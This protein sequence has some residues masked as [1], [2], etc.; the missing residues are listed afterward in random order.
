MRNIFEP[1][2][3]PAWLKQ[4]LS[5]IR[6][7]LGDIWPGPLRLKDYATV[8]RPAAADFS[9]GLIYDST[10]GRPAWSNGSAWFEAM[11]YT[12][13]AALSRTN[14]TNV[15]LTLGGSP[16]TA[17][18]AATSLTLGWIGT[19]SVA[20]G[21]SGAATL[22]GL[23]VGNGTSAFTTIAPGTGV[24]TALALN[25]GSAG[26]F[27]TFNGALGTP[28]SGTLTNATGL[29][30]STGVSG[31]ASGIATFL[32]TPSSTNLAA[33]VTNETG[34]GALVFATSPTLVTPIL[35]TPTS[36]TLTNC[37]GLPISSGVSGLGTGIAT[38]LATP[39]SANLASAL[40]DETGSGSVVFSV[41][42]TFTGTIAAAAASFSGNVNLGDAAAD[43]HVLKGSTKIAGGE[44]AGSLT[45]DRIGSL[46]NRFRAFVGDG[47]GFVADDNYISSLNT[48]L[49]F[50]AGG[51]GATEIMRLTSTGNILIVNTTSA[52][53]TPT[54]GGY[55]YVESGALKYRGSSGTVTTIAAA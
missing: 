7:A 9:G 21:G 24:A 37:T 15:T 45:L 10:D 17:L 23:L 29:P 8:D 22:T 32:A 26:A 30:I 54:G 4:V 48:D 1:S 12:A 33:A 20:R 3:A 46:V 47:T 35:G 55:L 19:L 27:V 41:S 31:L 52:P 44:G 36:G 40:T 13:G 25:V 49:H 38:F 18:L 2:D 53:G 51:T 34:S 43:S 14:D 16:T 42:P 5:S 11:P 28:S 50:L 39:S 6:S